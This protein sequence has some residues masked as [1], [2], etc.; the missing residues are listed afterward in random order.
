M[1]MIS[2]GQIV[3]VLSELQQTR[4][5]LSGRIAEGGYLHLQ[6]LLKVAKPRGT[7]PKPSYLLGVGK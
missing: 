7:A 2:F 6:I 5:H 4:D 1:K 3:F